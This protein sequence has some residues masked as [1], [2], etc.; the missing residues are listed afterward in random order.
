MPT[1]EILL[2]LSNLLLFLCLSRMSWKARTA[3]N[4]AMRLLTDDM[5]FLE[6]RD[7]LIKRN[8]ESC[9]LRSGRVRISTVSQAAVTIPQ[10]PQAAWSA[11]LHTSMHTRKRQYRQPEQPASVL[12]V[13]YALWVT[14]WASRDTPE[15]PA[16]GVKQ[17][18]KSTLEQN[19]RQLLKQNHQPEC[20]PVKTPRTEKGQG[21]VVQDLLS[22][23]AMSN[24]MPCK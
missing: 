11:A 24:A 10:D 14:T 22:F 2:T 18:Q 15:S 5:F 4:I 13:P 7:E 6:T 19:D 3:R 21:A 23:G 12:E 17:G 1:T 9:R 20:T 16:P 8:V